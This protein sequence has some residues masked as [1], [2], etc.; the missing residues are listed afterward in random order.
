MPI[1]SAR[2][3]R[4]LKIVVKH[5]KIIVGANVKSLVTR[6]CIVV[7]Y[8]SLPSYMLTFAKYQITVFS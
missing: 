7:V 5:T 6:C 2:M 1:R 3:S 8:A 4:S